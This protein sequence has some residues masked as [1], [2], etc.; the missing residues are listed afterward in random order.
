MAHNFLLICLGFVILYMICT[1]C[2]TCISNHCQSESLDSDVK[3]AVH[4]G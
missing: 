2:V 4:G 1:V 3:D